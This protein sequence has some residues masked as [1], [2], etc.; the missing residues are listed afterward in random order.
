VY[1]TLAILKPTATFS[2]DDLERIVRDVAASGDAE[3]SR[4]GRTVRIVRGEAYL[5]ISEN[6]DDY[7]PEECN[8]IADQLS[9]PR[10]NFPKR[11]EFAAEDPDMELFND[12]LLVAERLQKTGNFVIFDRNQGKLLFD[13]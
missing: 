3:V 9:I 5:E 1:E 13:G 12:Y 4:S 6:S 7:V 8:E 2:L 11:Y 10:Q